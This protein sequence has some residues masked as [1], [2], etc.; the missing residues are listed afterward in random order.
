MAKINWKQPPLEHRFMCWSNRDPEAEKRHAI[1]SRI[2]LIYGDDPYEMQKQFAKAGFYDYT[3][4]ITDEKEFPS[5]GNTSSS[6]SKANEVPNLDDEKEFP[7]LTG[8]K[9]AKDLR[10]T[11]DYFSLG[12][13]ASREKLCKKSNPH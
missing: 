6:N 13:S 2:Y 10:P 4:D 8:F 9:R 11:G 5:L 7:P 3:G 1:A 12:S